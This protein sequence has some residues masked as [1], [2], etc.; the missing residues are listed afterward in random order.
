MAIRVNS[1]SG[2]FAA[3]SGLLMAIGYSLTFFAFC[4]AAPLGGLLADR[5]G[6]K[7]ILLASNIGYLVLI[8]VSLASLAVGVLPGWLVWVFLLGRTACQSVQITTLASSVPILVRKR[9]LSQ[10][11]GSRLFL[12]TAVAA[13]E[14]PL[15]VALLP[16]FGLRT[17]ILIT[18]VVLI[19]TIIYVARAEIPPGR[20]PEIAAGPVTIRGYKPLWAYIRSRRG[21]VALFGFFAVFNFVVGFAEIAD[22]SITQS[23]GS[24]ATL[25]IVLGAG[26]ASMLATTV[27]ITIWGTPRKPIRWLLIFSVMLA[28]AL[29]LGATRP[30]LL[31]VTAAAVLFLGSAPFV[32]AIISTL[33]HTK[34]EPGLMGR[35]MG[36]QTLVVGLAY[37]GGNVVGGLCA[38]F[39]RPL[40]GGHRLSAGFLAY[41]VGT[42]WGYGRGYAF[43]AMIVAVMAIV[44]VL[45][46]GR[47]PSLR[48]LD[49]NLPD[50]TS[51]D[52]LRRQAPAEP[53]PAGTEQAQAAH[54]PISMQEMT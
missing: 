34:T 22:R 4:P 38:A 25:D 54:R 45:M 46:L 6:A 28:A 33:F 24:P 53:R 12:T 39:A 20:L 52:L 32:M 29:A 17:I 26:V 11:N 48:Y 7:R 10:A 44:I 2:L 35:M 37:G 42:G 16:A 19:A 40:A 14:I 21:L 1:Y 47:R 49:T 15:A 31:V 30:D 5:W 27:G 23:F 41:L 50:V 51:E 43:M 3:R 9:H 8:M 18:S 36:L 13:F